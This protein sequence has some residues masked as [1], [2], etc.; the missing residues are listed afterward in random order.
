M[1]VYTPAPDVGPL[2][3]ELEP[4]PAILQGNRPVQTRF[5]STVQHNIKFT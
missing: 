4:C 3:G 1:K 2:I 5:Q